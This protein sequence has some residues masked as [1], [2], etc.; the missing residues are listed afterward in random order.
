[1]D[2]M[3][4]V[5]SAGPPLPANSIG[6]ITVS[7]PELAASHSKAPKAASA[8]TS[9][10]ST[11]WWLCDMLAISQLV[12]HHSTHPKLDYIHIQGY[13]RCIHAFYT[14]PQTLLYTHMSMPPSPALILI[15]PFNTPQYHPRA[16]T[17]AEVCNAILFP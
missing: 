12:T 9:C 7:N 11:F 8:L 16:A 5:I 10:Q 6:I 4:N 1:M 17:K 14:A 3:I 15:H 2:Y 13:A